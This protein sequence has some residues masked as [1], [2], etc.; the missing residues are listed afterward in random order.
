MAAGAAG[1]GQ[2][3]DVGAVASAGVIER[4]RGELVEYALQAEH[5]RDA[6][7]ES[8]PAV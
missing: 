7:R 2:H 8:R 1:A 5:E 6:A 3:A 4:I